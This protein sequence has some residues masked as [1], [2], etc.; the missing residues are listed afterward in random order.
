MHRI[1]SWRSSA[2]S[3]SFNSSWVVISRAT[4]AAGSCVLSAI[5]PVAFCWL[6]NALFATSENAGSGVE[7]MRSNGLVVAQTVLVATRR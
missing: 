3:T 1:R 7:T 2:F 5:K 6:F 4:W